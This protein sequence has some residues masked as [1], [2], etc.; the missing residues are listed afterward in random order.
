MWCQ[1]YDGLNMYV[2]EEN[3]WELGVPPKAVDFENMGQ[4]EERLGA[5]FTA[6]AKALE[7]VHIHV[8]AST[9]TVL[10]YRQLTGSM[11]SALGYAQHGVSS[12]TDP[13]VY[14]WRSPATIKR[15]TPKSW[16]DASTCQEVLKE[17][18]SSDAGG[19]NRC[20]LQI[21][22]FVRP[23]TETNRERFRAIDYIFFQPS[24]QLATSVDT[25]WIKDHPISD[26]VQRFLLIAEVEGDFNMISCLGHSDG[27]RLNH[28]IGAFL[29]WIGIA[30]DEI[31]NFQA[32]RVA[33]FQ[34]LRS[35]QLGNEMTSLFLDFEREITQFVERSSVSPTL[36]DAVQVRDL[37]RTCGTKVQSLRDKVTSFTQ[38]AS[39]IGAQREPFSWYQSTLDFIQTC[40]AKRVNENFYEGGGREGFV[41][42]SRFDLSGVEDEAKTAVITFSLYHYQELLENLF[43]NAKRAW[44]HAG[45]VR[46]IQMFKITA[47]L[48]NGHLQLSF[49]SEGQEIED[50]LRSKLFRYPV[51]NE[52]RVTKGTGVGLWALGMGFKTFGLPLPVVDNE[53][54]F[55]PRFTFKFPAQR[56]RKL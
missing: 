10:P 43:K 20:I 21:P 55:G 22:Y 19:Q 7:A 23:I 5:F 39:T 46:D 40:G 34:L 17:L 44:T 1:I 3:E 52:A 42:P 53:V 51:P 18:N 28:L 49:A 30:A 50:V 12:Q 31:G 56:N 2:M 24:I 35:H 6:F 13:S 41:S 16:D 14:L 4:F 25:S 54:G 37:L 8:P 32:A 9:F 47:S 45:K 27:Q 15:F 38:V 36:N 26:Y 48:S 33:S 29:S 11:S